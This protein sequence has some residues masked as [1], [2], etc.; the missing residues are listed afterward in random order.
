NNFTHLYQNISSNG[1]H[2]VVVSMWPIAGASA[3]YLT[4]LTNISQ[5]QSTNAL[6]AEFVDST[7]VITN[8]AVQT[9]DA[10]AHLDEANNALLAGYIATRVLPNRS[11][12]FGKVARG[13]EH[14]TARTIKTEYVESGGVSVNGFRGGGRNIGVNL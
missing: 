9:E 7:V 11:K 12:L 5:W 4:N 13:N 10:V 3:A 14:L 1:G 6:V 8:A 2:V